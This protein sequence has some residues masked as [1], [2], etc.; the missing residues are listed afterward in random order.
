MSGCDLCEEFRRVTFT[1][2]ESP[3]DGEPFRVC[4]SCYFELRSRGAELVK[5]EGG[6]DA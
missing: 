3:S 1:R 5:I 4:R 2:V 6:S